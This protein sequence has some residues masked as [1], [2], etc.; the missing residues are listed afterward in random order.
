MQSMVP[1]QQGIL[2]M[3]FSLID[4]ASLTWTK[5]SHMEWAYLSPAWKKIV[6]IFIACL[7]KGVSVKSR[8]QSFFWITEWMKRDLQA[9][10][11]CMMLHYM[12]KVRSL[13]EE[14]NWPY[15]CLIFYASSVLHWICN[16]KR[17]TPRECVSAEEFNHTIRVLVKD[18]FS[19]LS[20]DTCQGQGPPVCSQTCAITWKSQG[21]S[22]PSRQGIHWLPFVLSTSWSKQ[23]FSGKRFEAV[24]P[25][26]L[27]QGKNHKEAR[28]NC[29]NLALSAFSSAALRKVVHRPI[30]VITSQ[31]Q[32]R[33]SPAF[34]GWICSSG[35][36]KIWGPTG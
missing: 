27:L 29:F 11:V 16:K 12:V 31:R 13:D 26:L 21:R 17:V 1:V 6:G 7:K 2:G 35:V 34:Q 19:S 33:L 30:S 32:K 36:W 20:E 8:D 28:K 5:L 22:L 3:C 9:F 15:L 25:Y 18:T 24:S 10:F 4:T 23:P 14:Q